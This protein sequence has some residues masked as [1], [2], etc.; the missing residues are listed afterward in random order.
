MSLYGKK[1]DP[2]PKPQPEFGIDNNQ[3]IYDNIISSQ[4]KN[5][6]IDI[7]ALQGFTSTAQ[8]RDEVYTLIDSMCKDSV[9]AS[10]LETYAEDAT[11]TND[12][13]Q[14]VWVEAEDPTI[15]AYV[16]YLLD[17]MGVDKHVYE[18]TYNLIKY[19]DTYLRLYRESDYDSDVLQK[20]LV[21]RYDKNIRS[22][23]IMTGI[24]YKE[25]YDYF[26]SK[27]SLEEAIDL[28]KKRSRHYAKRQYTWFNNQ[29]NIKWFD[30]DFNNFDNTF[31]S[32]VKYIEENK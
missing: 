8:S 18:W 12:L 26:D 23:A 7:N 29:M 5:G 30:V 25:L 32:V 19:G 31:K 2:T 3:S 27:I 4:G 16:E 14:V 6:G 10:V 9:V 21:N 11:E 22:K 20:D 28:I 17:T 24:G 13:G 15:A 1:T